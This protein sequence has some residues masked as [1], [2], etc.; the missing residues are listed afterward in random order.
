LC[1]S[2]NTAAKQFARAMGSIEFPRARHIQL[3]RGVHR[4]IRHE[5]M[6]G[7]RFG[8]RVQ[9]SRRPQAI[10]AATFEVRRR[11]ETTAKN[12]DK[13][14]RGL[15]GYAETIVHETTR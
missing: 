1:A 14:V 7:R 3:R 12:R 2:R 11:E 9:T 4:V 13:I 8:Y 6:L 5:Q 15:V 10:F